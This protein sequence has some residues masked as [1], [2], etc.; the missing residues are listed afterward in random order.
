MTRWRT[1]GL[2]VALALTPSLLLARVHP[3]GDAGL[4]RAA[5][6]NQP[7]DAAMPANVRTLLEAKC[8][9]CHSSQPRVPVY[10]HFAPVSWL[11]E[12]D[13]VKARKE[14]NLSDWA[15][16]T[17]DQQETLRAKILEQV[18]TRAMPL[19]QY[20]ALHWSSRLT[21]A[22]AQTLA[23]WAHGAAQPPESGG[24]A[25]LPGDAVRGQS[26]FERRCT[27]CH[28]LTNDRE[29]P[30]LGNVY[31]RKAGSIPGFPYSDALLHANVTWDGTALDKWLTEPDSFVP[32][33]NMDFRVPKAQERLDL[34]AFFAKQSEK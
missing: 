12:K 25:I 6:R 18:R 20:R 33:V 11:L 21:D 15:H 4:Y 24:E 14:M 17:P 34:I 2:S 5:N 28:S 9:D 16:Y 3:F 31:G 27:G 29:G 10:G 22:D 7:I 13:I 32:G 1:L 8:A 19:P 23:A 30:R 26:V